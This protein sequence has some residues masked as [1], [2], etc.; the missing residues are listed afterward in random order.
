MLRSGQRVFLMW[1]L[2]TFHADEKFSS[3]HVLATFSW[4]YNDLA[5]IFA[6]Y[7]L[8]GCVLLCSVRVTP[9]S[10]LFMYASRKQFGFY[11]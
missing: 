4:V 6:A 7:S 1:L 10:N 11:D 5:Q 2:M 8:A 3:E 9:V